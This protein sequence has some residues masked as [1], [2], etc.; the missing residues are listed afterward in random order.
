[1]CPELEKRRAFESFLADHGYT[2]APVTIDN[3]EYIYAAV[4]ADALRRGH[5]ETATR[6]G[7]NYLRYM[8][9]VFAF[10]EDVP[11]RIRLRGAAPTQRR[12]QRAPS[13]AC[14]RGGGAERERAQIRLG[15]VGSAAHV[16]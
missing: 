15:G 2:V 13:I 5:R 1:V 9:A 3:D 14:C 12:F 8:E 7:E 6:V 16:T 11:R 10:V 4:Y